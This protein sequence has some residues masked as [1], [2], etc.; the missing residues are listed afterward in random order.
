MKL[1]AEGEAF[2]H[3][4]LFDAA[5][6]AEVEVPTPV[7]AIAR[8]QAIGSIVMTALLHEAR[9][10]GVNTIE[11]L[12][13]IGHALGYSCRGETPATVRCLEEF[14]LE[15]V[16]TGRAIGMGWHRPQHP[17]VVVYCRRCRKAELVKSQIAATHGRPICCGDP[18]SIDP[19]SERA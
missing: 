19:P 6:L 4:L 5:R 7:L 3:Q 14:F 2:A 9:L 1:T 11:L 16:A 8:T 17:G 13:G 18:M 15:G 12:E 10:T